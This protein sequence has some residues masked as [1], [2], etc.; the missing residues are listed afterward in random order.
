MK[1]KWGIFV[2]F[3]SIPTNRSTLDFIPKTNYVQFVCCRVD[4]IYLKCARFNQCVFENVLLKWTKMKVSIHLMCVWHNILECIHICSH[5][6]NTKLNNTTRHSNGRNINDITNYFVT[7]HCSVFFCASSEMVVRLQRNC[8]TLQNQSGN[9]LN[10]NDFPKWFFFPF[11]WS[12]YLL[13]SHFSHRR[14]IYSSLLFFMNTDFSLFFQSHS[15]R[16]FRY[17]RSHWLND[18]IHGFD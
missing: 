12:F 16:W 3:S 10:R 5:A 18:L 4:D 6:T 14:A 1:R 11:L 17:Y 7:T 8:V 2:I 13:L 15:I 9:S